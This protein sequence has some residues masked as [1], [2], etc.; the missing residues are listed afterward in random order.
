MATVT[1]YINPSS[2]AGGDGTTN[3]TSGAN[4][5]YATAD[6]WENAEDGLYT[7]GDLHIVYCDAGADTG[8]VNING[9]AATTAGGY[10]QFIAN[11]GGLHNGRSRD[12]SG[13]GY[14]LSSPASTPTVRISEEYV[15]FEGLCFKQDTDQNVFLPQTVGASN[16]LQIDDCVIHRTVN[17][18]TL[19]YSA[20]N[21]NWTI[22]NCVV[23]GTGWTIDSRPGTTCTLRYITSYTT[24]TFN[25]VTNTTDSIKNCYGAGGSS[26]VFWSGGSNTG[27]HNASSDTSATTQFTSSYASKAASSQFT[28]VA[29][30]STADFHLKS[31][32]FLIGVGT[33]ITGLDYD[34]ENSTRNPSTPDIGADEFTSYS[35]GT[36]QPMNLRM[37]NMLQGAQRFGRGF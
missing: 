14:C 35:A 19:I 18:V 4:R 10:I 24:H 20:S 5:A 16:A 34:Y 8:G 3:A 15:R 27:D 13:S 32:A 11:T 33:P 7:T 25:Y 23:Y 22:N 2:T 37:S 28:T 31:G 30:D 17:N 36:G 6:E 29:T 21:V 12:A 26:N 1:R 9:W